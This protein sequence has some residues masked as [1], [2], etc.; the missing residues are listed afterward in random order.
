MRLATARAALDLTTALIALHLGPGPHPDGSPQAVHAGGAAATSAEYDLI[1]RNLRAAGIELREDGRIGHMIMPDGTAL[2]PTTVRGIANHWEVAVDAGFLPQ[3]E[4]G[5]LTHSPVEIVNGLLK[6]DWI[7][8]KGPG[9]WEVWE[10]NA[11]NRRVIEDSGR[12]MGGWQ[13]N[14]W[15]YVEETGKGLSYRFQQQDLIDNDF[16]LPATLRRADT[17]HYQPGT[18]LD[19]VGL[20]SALARPASREGQLCLHRN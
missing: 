2:G 1:K 3:S 17:H 19:F 8:W 16:D 18:A 13:D 10:I 14:R 4:L 5:H 6:R 9:E 7:R 12:K 15:W 20:A 11:F